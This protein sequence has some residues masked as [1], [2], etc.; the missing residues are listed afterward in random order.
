MF[1]LPFLHRAQLWAERLGMP[2]N[3]EHARKLLR[4]YVCN[5]HSSETE[6]TLGDETRLG[7][8]AVPNPS[9]VVSHSNSAWHHGGPSLKSPSCEE[10]LY[11]LVCTR[12]YSTK[13]RTSL[14]KEPIQIHSRHFLTFSY[15]PWHITNNRNQ[16]FFKRRH[17][18]SPWFCKWSAAGWGLGSIN[19]QSSFPKC[20]GWHCLIKELGLVWTQ[21]EVV[22]QN[23]DQKECTF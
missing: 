1:L 5:Q 4:Q 18:V 2:C 15:M 13:S 6:F 9:T 20:K 16:H 10:D 23:S 7:R 3:L 19:F 11:V 14:T 12:T 22:L 8:F 17:L 21:K